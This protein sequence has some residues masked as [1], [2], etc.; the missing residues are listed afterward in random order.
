M[1]KLIYI[2]AINNIK[3]DLDIT[4][5]VTFITG[6]SG[7]GKTY[8][9]SV[10]KKALLNKVATKYCSINMNRFVII[11]DD[12][13]I[14]N[15]VNLKDMSVVLVD[16]YDCFSI[17]SKK[18][19]WNKMKTANAAWIIMTRYLDFP[20]YAF[21]DMYSIEELEYKRDKNSLVLSFSKK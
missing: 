6:D 8:L 7:T 9:V 1:S 5:R 16:R 20:Q 19:L 15:L 18:K 12:L 14:S 2:S 3:F 17:E 10:I 21:K 4:A 11:E 13:T